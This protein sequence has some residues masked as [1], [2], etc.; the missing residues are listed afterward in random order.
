MP[1]R[2]FVIAG[3]A[4]G[5]A[6]GA[7]QL[8]RAEYYG[9][10]SGKFVGSFE[11]GGVAVVEKPLTFTDPRGLNWTA[12]AGIEVNGASIPRPLWSIVGSPFKGDYLR[13]SV[14]HDHYC[15]TMTRGWRETHKMFWHGCRAD[16]LSRVYANLL[17]AGVMR[18]GPRWIIRRGASGASARPKRVN[19]EFD[20]S[21]FRDLQKWIQNN[22]PSLSEIDTRLDR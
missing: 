4:A 11:R 8:A 9:R 18:F 2:R 5:A 15:V 19:P 3:L 13:A 17:Y 16:G 20:A 10:F 12:P 21:E 14:I 7:P 6:L 22:D 1:S